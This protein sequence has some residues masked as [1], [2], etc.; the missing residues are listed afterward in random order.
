MILRELPEH[1][2]ARAENQ[3]DAAKAQHCL[4]R[5]Y[6]P[7]A[8]GEAY[9]EERAHVLVDVGA[10]RDARMSAVRTLAEQKYTEQ[11][12]A[13]NAPRAPTGPV[14]DALREAGALEAHAAA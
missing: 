14:A 13:A 1:E 4:S 10:K 3:A 5:R 8:S 11:Q 9:A 2:A 7:N 12:T 6:G